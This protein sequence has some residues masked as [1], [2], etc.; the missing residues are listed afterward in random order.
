MKGRITFYV[1]D[2]MEIELV[3]ENKEEMDAVFGKLLE[4]GFKSLLEKE[5]KI[6]QS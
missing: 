3:F 5:G 2:M 6:Q 4:L 1:S